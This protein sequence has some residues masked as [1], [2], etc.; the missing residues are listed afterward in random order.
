[1][2]IDIHS[3]FLDMDFIRHLEGRPERPTSYQENGAYFVDCAPGLTHGS[4]PR[5]VNM[6]IKLREMELM[7]IDVSVLSPG[8]PGPECLNPGAPEEADYWASRINDYLA[9]L[10][11]AH[12]GKFL[13][14]GTLGYGDADRTIAEAD[15]CVRELGFKG[16]QLYSNVGGSVIDE[17][18]FLGVYEHV[19]TLGVPLNIHPTIPLNLVGM[20]AHG[21]IS[22]LGYMYDTSLALVRLLGAGVFDRSPSLKLIMPHVGGIVP[23]LQGRISRRP[24]TN[25]KGTLA[26]YLAMVNYDTVTYDL[27]ALEYCF[28]FAGAERLLYGTDVPF[29]D[30]IPAADAL[31]E[32]LDCTEAER[33]LIYHGNAERLLGIEAWSGITT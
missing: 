28:A 12:P 31:V 22:G 8:M 29:T 3:H 7:G 4:G 23:Y 9:G 25:A 5:I 27:A 18:A 21:L 2:R 30:A 24:L 11:D 16:F 15:R 20:D 13:G 10:I 1:M 19:A 26:S 32:R 14:W 33:E 6:D 17:P